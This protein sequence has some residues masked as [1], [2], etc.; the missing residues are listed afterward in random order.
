MKKYNPIKVTIAAAAVITAVPA[1][2]QS[3]VTLYGVVDTG[4][5]YL[6][7]SSS[8]G[9]THGG[10][11][12]LYMNQGVWSGSLVGLTGT[13]DLGGGTKAILKLEGGYNSATGG[14]QFANTLFGRQAYVGLTNNQY[15]TLTAGRQYTS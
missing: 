2:A 3:S 8:L 4:L 10:R 13:D 7:N 5:G 12:K 6:S 9:A 15:G 1:F 11:S 14:L